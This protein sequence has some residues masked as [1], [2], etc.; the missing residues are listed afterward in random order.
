MFK[1]LLCLAFL[2]VHGFPICPYSSTFFFSFPNFDIQRAWSLLKHDI[3][4]IK[5]L[6]FLIS[7]P[8]MIRAYFLQSCL[9]CCCLLQSHQYPMLVDS[10]SV[11]WMA[12]CQSAF[13]YDSQ[14]LYVCLL[15]PSD[16]SLFLNLVCK[17]LRTSE[18]F[19]DIAKPHVKPYF[20][21]ICVF[22]GMAIH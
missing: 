1:T 9:T 2:F 14:L 15:L 7:Y 3:I 16:W 21:H 11:T 6:T 4:A 19:H 10:N 8:F 18:L 12:S 17:L 20:I 13:T 5:H 22:L